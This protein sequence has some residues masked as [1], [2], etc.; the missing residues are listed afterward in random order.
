M[1]K[2]VFAFA[3]ILSCTVFAC[4]EVAQPA[5]AEK[6]HFPS[7]DCS[8]EA[9]LPQGTTRVYIALTNGKDGVRGING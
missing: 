8:A 7:S 2:T 1:H 6:A 5:A 9:K 3:M 4:G